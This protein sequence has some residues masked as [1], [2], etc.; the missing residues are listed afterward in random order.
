M[1]K[2]S[3]IIPTRDRTKLLNICLYHISI[4]SFKDFEVIIIND[5]NKK[6]FIY[7]FNLDI[8]IIESN[9]QK[10]PGFSRNI[11]FLNIN[12][13]YAALIDDDCFVHKDWAFYIKKNIIDKNLD[14]VKGKV[15]FNGKNI[16]KKYV[17]LQLWG[18]NS[19]SDFS[20][21]CNV[22]LK[23]EITKKFKFNE[24]FTFAFEDVDFF[25]RVNK[26]YKIYFDS[27]IKLLHYGKT[28][29]NNI[30][31]TYFKYG[32]GNFIYKKI[33]NSN[34]KSESFFKKYKKQLNNYLKGLEKSFI[35]YKYAILLYFITIDIIKILHYKL[36][37]YYEKHK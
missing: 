10:G 24:K 14:C 13:N 5:S 15:I 22:I 34:I 17:N 2:F 18:Y 6:L 26:Q 8:K 37:Y 9:K 36:G 21:S 33:N 19:Y 25:E 23:K 1:A 20:S 3:I 7:N 31:S 32:Q 12:S 27:K 11:G 29:L 16:L 35:F 30:F 4:Q 28:K